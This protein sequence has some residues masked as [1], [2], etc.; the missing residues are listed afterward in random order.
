MA[1]KKSALIPIFR[2]EIVPCKPNPAAT[3]VSGK[4][5][6]SLVQPRKGTSLD[7]FAEMIAAE[8][9][10]RVE[11]KLADH[12]RD[13]PAP[14]QPALMA[15]KDA[16]VYLGRTEQ[17]IQHLIASKEL[18]VVRAGRRVH[19]HRSDLDAWIEKNKY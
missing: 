10:I 11:K 8:V 15:V 7:T 4:Q 9:A 5:L 14:I 18:P 6:A 3:T 16:A 12:F 13:T 19:L 17:A 2:Y 1:E